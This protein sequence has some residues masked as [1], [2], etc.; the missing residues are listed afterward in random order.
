MNKRAYEA[1]YLRL[2]AKALEHQNIILELL[3]NPT[4]GPGRTDLIDALEDHL[5][6]LG[7]YEGALLL[8]ANRFQ[9]IMVEAQKFPRDDQRWAHLLEKID[10]IAHHL[11]PPAV[12]LSEEDLSARSSAFRNSIGAPP[13]VT[14]APKKTRR[15]KKKMDSNDE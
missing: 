1:L 9:S 4:L 5:L 15:K 2:K 12:S 3:E 14:P 6:K 10:A 11:K 8:L 13:P 7:E